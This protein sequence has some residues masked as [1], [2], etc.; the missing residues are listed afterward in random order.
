MRDSEEIERFCRKV[1]KLRDEGLADRIIA[2]RMGCSRTTVVMR[3]KQHRDRERAAL[4]PCTTSDAALDDSS[5]D[6]A[7]HGVESVRGDSD[8]V[9]GVSGSVVGVSGSAQAFLGSGKR[10]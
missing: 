4:D 6:A 5:D 3:M 2:E 7:A 9:V 8:A 10:P 1:K